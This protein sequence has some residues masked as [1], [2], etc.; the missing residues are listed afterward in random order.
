MSDD[1]ECGAVTEIE[2]GRGN[3]CSRTEITLS[4]FVHYCVKW[5]DD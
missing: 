4:H 1:N 3:L 5:W 2:I